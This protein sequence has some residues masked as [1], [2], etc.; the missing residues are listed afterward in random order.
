MPVL[1]VIYSQ[2]F[3]QTPGPFAGLIRCG[4]C[5]L[6]ITAEHKV[7]H[8]GS[9]YTYYH[10]TKKR[11]DVRCGQRVISA[12]ELEE[13]FRDFLESVTLKPRMFAWLS[14]R[15]GDNR[16]NTQAEQEARLNSLARASDALEKERS[17]LTTLRLRDLVDDAEFSKK[18]SRIDW[19]KQKLA[20]ARRQTEEPESW[21]EPAK[22]LI[23]GCNRMAF[24]FDEGD[25]LTKRNIV[26]AVGSNSTLFDQKLLCEAAFPFIVNAKITAHSNQLAVLESI[27]TLWE[28]R[29]PKLLK[30][31]DIFTRLLEQDLQRKIDRGKAA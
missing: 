5:G 11:L 8:S 1:A 23:S 4:E 16:A 27:R 7:N 26:D 14:A 2:H 15:L 29:D 6:M 10:C 21:V 13:Q 12:K 9:R 22:I 25:E 20:E 19:E 24:W 31:V 30:A 28:Q 18:R 17:N 3:N